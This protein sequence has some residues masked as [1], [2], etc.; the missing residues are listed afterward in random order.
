MQK[1]KR[2]RHIMLSACMVAVLCFA[3]S[4][5][6]FAMT[7]SEIQDQVNTVG[8]ETASGN[9]LIWFLCAIAFLKV[10][11][12]ID[13]FMSSLGINVGHTGGSMLAEAMVAARGI[14]GLK[15]FSSQHFGGGHSRFSSHTSTG[16]KGLLSGGLAGMVGS[17]ITNS[18][19]KSATASSKTNVSHSSRKSG[20]GIGGHIYASSVS[21]GGNFANNVISTVATGNIAELGFMSGPE[22]SQALQSYLGYAALGENAPQVPVFSDVEIGGGRITGTETSEEHPQGIAFGMYHAAQYAAPDGNYTTIQA[23]DGSSWYKQYAQD[24]VDKTPYMAPDGSIAYKESI[25]KKLPQPPKRRE[26]M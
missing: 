16:S 25:V 10:S 11:Q 19:V 8:R 23:A 18:A 7:E 26:R 15:N 9:V 20:G 17:R 3:F 12:K 14:G 13:S 1:I 21:K 4:Q 22:A 24:A 6:V 5:P 2:Y